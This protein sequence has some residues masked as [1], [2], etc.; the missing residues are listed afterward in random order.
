MIRTI[1][2]VS[3]GHLCP[4]TCKKLD[5]W[6]GRIDF[7]NR[8]SDSAMLPVFMGGT[9]FGWLVRCMNATGFTA[10]EGDNDMPADLLA[11]L[12]VGD[13]LGVDFVLFDA[14]AD[15]FASMPWGGGP[16][17]DSVREAV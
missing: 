13:C 6:A 12:T 1:L 11:C 7:A 15:E 10:G 4:A 17:G 16:S 8:K 14:D 2:E 5:A 3:T 9:E